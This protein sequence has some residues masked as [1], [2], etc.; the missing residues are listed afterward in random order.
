[1]KEVKV[2]TDVVKVKNKR[3]FKKTEIEVVPR[4]HTTFYPEPQVRR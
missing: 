3:K 1:M 2:K 4:V